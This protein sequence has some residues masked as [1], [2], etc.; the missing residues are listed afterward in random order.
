MRFEQ[1]NKTGILQKEKEISEMILIETFYQKSGFATLYK[2]SSIKLKTITV[3]SIIV[4]YVSTYEKLL[5]K[6]SSSYFVYEDAPDIILDINAPV[7]GKTLFRKK[8]PVAIF[9]L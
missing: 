4:N 7:S 5:S 6:K 2:Y 8:V 9:A 1:T 3:Y